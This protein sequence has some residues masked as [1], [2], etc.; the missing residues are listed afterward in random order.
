MPT[1]NL[2]SSCRVYVAARY[3]YREH[4][5]MDAVNALIARGLQP[6][7]RWVWQD[8]PTLGDGDVTARWAMTNMADIQRAD[9]MLVV[10]EPERIHTNG[11]RHVELGIA[12]ALGKRIVIWGT[13][14]N[15]FYWFP[16]IQ[17]YRSLDSAVDALGRCLRCGEYLGAKR[18]GFF[19][20][21]VCAYP[22]AN[23][24]GQLALELIPGE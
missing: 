18:I 6:T 11:G 22:P 14:E 16:G 20:G 17:A 5:A 21:P 1:R 10:S 9:A 19:C 3:S 15:T 4:K 23:P 24:S 13:R 8:D 12:L 7:S 2:L